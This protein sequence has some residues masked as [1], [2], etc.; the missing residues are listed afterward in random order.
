M[1]KHHLVVKRIT[2]DK[3]LPLMVQ[4]PKLSAKIQ[5][6]GSSYSGLNF[7]NKFNNHIMTKSRIMPVLG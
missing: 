2:L 7:I 5:I 4:L 6:M 3:Q 1:D